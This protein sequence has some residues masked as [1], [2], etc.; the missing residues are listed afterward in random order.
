MQR[1][2]QRDNQTDIQTETNRHRMKY[3]HRHTNRSICGFWPPVNRDGHI[4]AKS[5]TRR[6][7]I[8]S[9]QPKTIKSTRSARTMHRGSQLT[10]KPK[11]RDPSC[12]HRDSVSPG[13]KASVMCSWQQL[14]P[15]PITTSQS[16]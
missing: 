11:E 13:T 9:R 16:V 5:R 12:G 1:D 15:T 10:L 2:R 7:T 3:R 4:K 8:L 14:T 6:Q